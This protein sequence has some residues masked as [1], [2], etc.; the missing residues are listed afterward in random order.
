MA[1]VAEL[2]PVVGVA[3]ACAALGLPRA[4]FYRRTRAEGA[5]AKRPVRTAVQ[6]RAL[7]PSERETVVSRLHEERFLD[8]SPAAVY[9][10]LLDEGEYHCSIR[11]MYRILEE[12]GDGWRN[13]THPSFG[14][15]RRRRFGFAAA[16]F[17]RC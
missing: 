15:A 3:Q 9:A 7:S 16:N 8:V 1:G 10:T 5:A 17:D 6:P 4:S 14:R 11:T 12:E 2:A 13:A